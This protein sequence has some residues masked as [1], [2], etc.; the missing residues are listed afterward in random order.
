MART[1]R[2]N[3]GRGVHLIP[4]IP[5]RTFAY[6]A[7]VMSQVASVLSVVVGIAVVANKVKGLISD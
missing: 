7:T 5:D 4:K 6:Y 2:N 1:G 3:S